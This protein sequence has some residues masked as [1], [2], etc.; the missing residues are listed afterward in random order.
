MHKL[1]FVFLLF[2]FLFLLSGCGAWGPVAV[3]SGVGGFQL[4][5]SG[6]MQ[7]VYEVSLEGAYVAALNTMDSLR[8]EVTD[9]E[10]GDKRRI[11]KSRDAE[12]GSEITIDLMRMPTPN[13]VKASFW[14]VKHRVVP[15]KA[16]S[17][18]VMKEFNARLHERQKTARNV[19]KQ[20]D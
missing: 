1:Y 17:M 12:S 13:Y 16:Y 5:R 2:P 8:L 20:G 11:V 18:V 3:S 10:I 6:G 19:Q 7:E 4:Y 9:I 14:S 15:N